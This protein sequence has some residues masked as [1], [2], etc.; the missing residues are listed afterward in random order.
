MLYF[1]SSF[2]FYNDHVKLPHIDAPTPPE[3]SGNTKFYPFFKDALGAIDGTHINCCPTTADRQAARDRKGGV[4]QNC[5]AIC[6]FDMVFYYMF[7]GWEGPALDLTMF[8]DAHVTDLP[9]PPG[10]Y[11]LADAGFPT[12]ASL[13]IPIR[14]VHYHLQEWGRANLR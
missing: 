7:S 10:R 11:Y 12:C 3:I 5:L 1:F 9:I 14:G 13:L 6:G 4:T 2:P 8:H